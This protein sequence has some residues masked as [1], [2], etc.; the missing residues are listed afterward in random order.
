MSSLRDDPRAAG[1]E[2]WWESEGVVVAIE[3]A[4]GIIVE[5]IILGVLVEL[6]EVL[7][8]LR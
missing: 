3:I 6:L 8:G 5:L 4:G 2:S 7:R 1:R